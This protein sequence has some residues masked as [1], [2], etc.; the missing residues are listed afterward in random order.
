MAA[1]IDYLLEHNANLD[2][3]EL[4]PGAGMV[5]RLCP[6]CRE[7]PRWVIVSKRDLLADI[8]L[9]LSTLIRKLQNKQKKKV[10]KIF[11]AS[12]PSF[13]PPWITI[14]NLLAMNKFGLAVM[15]SRK[16]NICRQLGR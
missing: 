11:G 1:N 14:Y 10:L 6:P 3:G 8:M 16:G 15:E 5:L 9:Q 13:Y 7:I 4:E 2:S 12:F